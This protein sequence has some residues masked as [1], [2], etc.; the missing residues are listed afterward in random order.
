[1]AAEDPGS[2]GRMCFADSLTCLSLDFKT[3]SCT[4]INCLLLLLLALFLLFLLQLLHLLL[5]LLD[6]HDYSYPSSSDYCDDDYS[7]S[8]FSSSCSFFFVCCC[9]H[10]YYDDD[11]TP[12]IIHHN[13]LFCEF[14]VMIR[15][16][17][18]ALA[19]ASTT[20]TPSKSQGGKCRT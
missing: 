1:M 5:L 18:M 14:I 8:S 4:V 13:R 17:E 9:C 15:L 20:K 7:S 2:E 19:G 12:T 3:H 16:I 10:Y 11:D 6:S